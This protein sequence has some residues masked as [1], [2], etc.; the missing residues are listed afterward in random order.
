MFGISV[1]GIIVAWIILLT[2]LASL[3]V[4][5]HD[6]ELK[7]SN[8]L[9]AYVGLW[10]PATGFVVLALIAFYPRKHAANT[11]KPRT[12]GVITG[13]VV[14]AMVVI[15]IVVSGRASYYPKPE[16]ESVAG[17]LTEEITIGNDLYSIYCTEC[18]GPDGEGGIIE[19][20]EGLEGVELKS[21]SSIDEM[22]TRT[23]E[24]LY[25]ITAFG[26]QDLG[27]PPFGLAYGGELKKADIDAIVTFMRYNWDE[28]AEIPV[29]AVLGIPELKEGEVPSY[30]VH[31]SAIAKR[32]C[33]SC[34][35]EGKENN[36]YLMGSYQEILTTG[37]NAPNN[38]IAV[39]PQNSYLV[40]TM[41][42]ESIYDDGGNE[43][44]GPMPP[45]KEIPGKYIPIFEQWIHHSMPE[46]DEDAG[47]LTQSV[48]VDEAEGES[49][50]P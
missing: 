4:A 1:M 10:I 21:I 28:R 26:Q 50:E 46:T 7:I 18:H 6:A 31:I 3:P 44:I 42:R 13:I 39:D 47:L 2:V 19:G 25:L 34:H 12:Y 30:E 22:W 45:S 37:D 23:D 8:V 41:Q 27:M 11:Q 38:V 43:I 14:V 40:Q 32:Y 33:V 49:Q 5:P 16:A 17:S 35:R 9:Q 24:T 48:Q 15:S 36:N 20:V 29:E